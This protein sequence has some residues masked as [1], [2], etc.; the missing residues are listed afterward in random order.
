MASSPLRKLK[1]PKFD[2]TSPSNS[3]MIETWIGNSEQAATI[4]LISPIVKI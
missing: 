4:K 3:S 2:F 1:S